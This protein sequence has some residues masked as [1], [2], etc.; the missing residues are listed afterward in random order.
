MKTFKKKTVIVKIN[1]KIAFALLLSNMLCGAAKAST[2]SDLQGFE[3]S[4]GAGPT[5]SNG[6]SSQMPITTQE[7]DTAEVSH[8]NR[9]TTYQLGVGYHLFADTLRQRTFLNDLLIQLNLSRN[10]ATITGDDLEFGSSNWSAFSFSSP[11]RSTTLMLEVKPSLFTIYHISPYPLFGA[12]LSWNRASF[13]EQ[14]FAADD[15]DG[16]VFLPT[17]TQKNFA[18][19][20][21]FGVRDA[22]T[23]NLNISLEY[24][25]THLG[26]MTPSGVATGTQTVLAAPSFYLKNQNILLSVGWA[27]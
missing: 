19:D 6:D 25:T 13:S 26:K 2:A 18:Y 9:S 5:W 1:S 7:T 24:R 22:L 8:I 23:K 27:F 14:A 10:N 20:F 21:G 17:R 16:E 4:L 11:I 15:V 3:I 12:G